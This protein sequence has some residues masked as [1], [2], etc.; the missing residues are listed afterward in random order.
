[1]FISPNST[2]I[3]DVKFFGSS[4]YLQL[5]QEKYLHIDTGCEKP[6]SN[7]NLYKFAYFRRFAVP[8][9][10]AKTLVGDMSPNP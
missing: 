9:K 5:C 10:P 2:W 8:G 6:A 3:I 7:A 1:M 4:L